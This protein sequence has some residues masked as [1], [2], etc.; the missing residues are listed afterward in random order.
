QVQSLLGSIMGHNNVVVSVT[1][2]ID[3]TQ[4]NRTEDLVEPVDLDNM[5]GITISA[6]RLEETYTGE[7]AAGG[8]PQAEDPGD[9]FEGRTYVEGT[10]D[11]GDY[12]RTEETINKEVNRIR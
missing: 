12:E 7:G 9:T 2:D 1:A 3:F 11:S 10:G 8:V 5:E 4:E 6:Q